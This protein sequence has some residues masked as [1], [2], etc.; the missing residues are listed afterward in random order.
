MAH[1]QGM[2]GWEVHIVVAEV[3]PDTG[4][5]EVHHT[6]AVVGALHTV[7]VVVLHTVLVGAVRHIDLVVVHRIGLEVV[8]HTDP[9]EEAADPTAAEEVELR[10][11]LEEVVHHTD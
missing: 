10:T 1:I 7:P 2:A 8:H 4:L 5:V 11:G 6:V 3:E 9:V